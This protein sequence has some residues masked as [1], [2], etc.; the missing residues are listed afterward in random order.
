MTKFT[1]SDR[2]GDFFRV[3]SMTQIDSLEGVSESSLARRRP[4]LH[5]LSHRT[6]EVRQ[7]LIKIITSN[8]SLV[9]HLEVE[10]TDDQ[11]NVIFKD[12]E[13]NIKPG[14]TGLDIEICTNSTN[15][16]IAFR[17]FN[18]FEVKYYENLCHD[19]LI[20]F[21][22]A[23]TQYQV[24]VVKFIANHK[25]YRSA[26]IVDDEV[27]R[28]TYFKSARSDVDELIR[29]AER[30]ISSF[31]FHYEAD[32]ILEDELRMAIGCHFLEYPTQYSELVNYLKLKGT[33][34]HEWQ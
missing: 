1:I 6:E 18:T 4:D 25:I 16:L 5:Y 21:N 32:T 28:Y 7:Q 13:K 29:A 15:R 34:Y 19:D 33:L 11:F 23:L 14:F 24:D 17:E 9:V 22:N 12:C 31:L 27:Y 10:L 26:V 2:D 20:Y 30:Y 8:S 3:A